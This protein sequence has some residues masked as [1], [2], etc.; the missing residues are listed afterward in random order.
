M[1]VKELIK[2]LEQF[3]DEEVHI[4]I[5][6]YYTNIS[7]YAYADTDSLYLRKDGDHIDLIFGGRFKI[8]RR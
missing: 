7:R 8:A 1:T 6:E 3:E 5:A 4:Q 2:R